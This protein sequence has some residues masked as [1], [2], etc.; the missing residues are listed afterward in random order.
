MS[1]DI[2]QAPLKPMAEFSVCDTPVPMWYCKSCKL[3]DTPL[4]HRASKDLYVQGAW[5]WDCMFCLTKERITGRIA[6]DGGTY[7]DCPLLS[8]RHT[9]RGCNGCPKLDADGKGSFCPHAVR[10]ITVHHAGVDDLCN[11]YEFDPF[12]ADSCSLDFDSYWFA[13]RHAVVRQVVNEQ[14]WL[15]L[16]DMLRNVNKRMLAHAAANAGMRPGAATRAWKEICVWADVAGYHASATEDRLVRR[17]S[18]EQTLHMRRLFV[19]TERLAAQRAE[20]RKQEKSGGGTE[21]GD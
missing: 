14:G 19:Y 7:D 13:L 18:D 5:P 10:R 15:T 11:R 6:G 2:K 20:E 17:T 8:A 9:E 21:G 4:C 1:C 12:F 3:H 16:G